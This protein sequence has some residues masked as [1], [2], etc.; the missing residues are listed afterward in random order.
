MA[1]PGKRTSPI[2]NSFHHAQT[3]GPGMLDSPFGKVLTANR[4]IRSQLIAIFV[5]LVLVTVLITSSVAGF[6]VTESGQQQ[7]TKQ[8]EAVSAL[9]EARIGAWIQDIQHN[10]QMLV[11]I[12]SQPDQLQMIEELVVGDTN[13]DQGHQNIT[14]TLREDYLESMRAAP[15]FE[16]IFLIDLNGKVLVSTDN[17]QIGRIKL[18][19][20]Y[21][22]YGIQTPYLTPVYL[23][24]NL[25]RITLV[26]SSPIQDL[27]G[28]T[29]AVLAGRVNMAVLN[30]IMV[31]QAG[32]G[33]TGEIY[34]IGENHIILSPSRFEGTSP[35]ETY[36]YS[37]KVSEILEHKAAGSGLYNGYRGV[38]VIG[39]HR[40]LPEL[41]MAL[42]TEQ[43]QSEAL[44][45]TR[46]T[47]FANTITAIAAMLVA[48]LIGL[49]ATR[50][51]TR[52]LRN[53][54]ETAE[55]IAAGNLNLTAKIER[56]DE[57]GALAHAFNSM[58]SQLKNLI[59]D[60]E[61]RIRDRTLDLENRSTQLKLAGQIAR[62]ISRSS[63]LD[64]LLTKAALLIRDRFNY[65]HVGIFL[66]DDRGEFAILKSAAGEA[67]LELLEQGYRQQVHLSSMI[68]SAVA[69]GITR[70]AHKQDLE[71]KLFDNP[72]LPATQTEAVIPL[73]IGDRIT[74]ALD[75]HSVRE[76]D[77]DNDTVEVLQTM[78][79]Q[80]A[81]AIENMHLIGEMQ[82]TVRK[83]ESAYGQY[84]VGTWQSF[85]QRTRRLRGLRYRGLQSEPPSGLTKEAVEAQKLH[86][87]VLGEKRI[88][89]GSQTMRNTLAIPMRLRGQ[90]LGVVNVE[91]EGYRPTP[92][93]IAF[94]EEVT[95]RL[96]LALDNV[97]L[98]EETNLRSEQLK[99]LQ[100]ITAAAASHVN[101]ENLFEDVTARIRAG[102]EAD[103]C[104]VILFDHGR[105]IGTL[106]SSSSASPTTSAQ[107]LLGTIIPLQDNQILEDILNHGTKSKI[108]S[109]M[110]QE[111]GEGPFHELLD[112][113]G[114]TTHVF[115]A[116]ES[117]GELLGVIMINVAD[118]ERQF[119]EDDLPLMNQISLQITTAIEVARVF[120]RIERRAQRERQ[121]SEIT[122]KVRASTNIDIILQ[123]A[124]QELAE[125]L[126]IPKGT[127]NLR[128]ER[129]SSHE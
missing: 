113:L 124:V 127:I 99:L 78:V 51:I 126:D 84:T 111:S 3:S 43:Y 21:F 5:L 110:G 75:L 109:E 77:F 103:H 30:E 47:L 34:L 42:L 52:P 49:L 114:A 59:R 79:D 92:E 28:E 122:S 24:D 89:T 45:T 121:I 22:T 115:V 54:A 72:L 40:W 105:Q 60:L 65:Y 87:T 48:L 14:Q 71:K 80:I 100:E 33:E 119:G 96:A 123:T 39:V 67:G 16:E 108:W 29:L 70:V 17:Q 97:R 101:L 6:L 93:T 98:I 74:G 1:A 38:P 88:D 64:E 8:L 104:G 90:T 11:I 58:T 35:R 10:L 53:L 66:L 18:S 94:Y 81:V 112:A 85:V 106:V 95:E 23:S 107:H 15:V 41:Q 68:G 129:G 20:D 36:F 37:Q 86:K 44:T 57:I 102:F 76:E 26:A 13:Q 116:L 7:V 56:E 46:A 50:R 82:E 62:D 63:D 4:S 9:K 32:L 12:Q 117:R 19:R 69:D 125:A 2:R 31:Q 118:P 128:R 61:D 25:G 91:F 73:I 83:L 55:E 120:E 27:N